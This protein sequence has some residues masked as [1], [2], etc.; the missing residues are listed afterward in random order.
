MSETWIALIIG[1]SA[2]SIAMLM[3]MGH[4]R[5]ERRRARLLR[6]LNHHEGWYVTRRRM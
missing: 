2:L 3:M 4:Y 1:G 6:H 5:R